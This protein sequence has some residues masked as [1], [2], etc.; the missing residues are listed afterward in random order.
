MDFFYS[1]PFTRIIFAS[2]RA[3]LVAV[4]QPVCLFLGNLGP[5][6]TID[7]VVYASVNIWRSLKSSEKYFL[8]FEVRVTIGF[9][10]ISVYI[11]YTILKAH[12]LTFIKP[13]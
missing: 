9:Y 12:F 8:Y 2:V 11:N 6:T 5:I 10:E 1:I 13:K 4:A 3:T 7:H